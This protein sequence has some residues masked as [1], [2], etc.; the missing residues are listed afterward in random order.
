M[1]NP[2]QNLATRSPLTKDGTYEWDY[3][4]SGY[5]FFRL[6]KIPKALEA[7]SIDFISKTTALC[8]GVGLPDITLN[9][10]E[11]MGLG[12]VKTTIPTN[13]D[14][15]T[16]FEFRF[17]EIQPS[18]PDSYPLLYL[19]AKWQN[20]I[21]NYFTGTADADVARSANDY[22]GAAIFVATDPSVNTPVLSIQ[23]LGIMP[24]TNPLSGYTADV[25]T[26]DYVEFS[27]TFAVDRVLPLDAGHPA[28]AE[29]LGIARTSIEKLK[30]TVPVTT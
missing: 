7:E 4:V 5:F 30:V 9:Y 13:I 15:A 11:R 10:S 8:V 24:N 19:L 17:L 26:N 12:G 25:T 27:V 21:R 6:N 20:S 18:S 28:V 23:L 1:P 14:Q 29:T 16:T 3:L 22:K 2:F